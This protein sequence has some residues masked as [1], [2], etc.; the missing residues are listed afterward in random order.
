MDAQIYHRLFVQ[1]KDG[2]AV[3]DE[4]RKMFADCALFEAGNIQETAYRIGKRDVVKFI[5]HK[6]DAA[7]RGE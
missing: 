1:D 4:L 6:C 5:Q 2:A 7:A 3:L